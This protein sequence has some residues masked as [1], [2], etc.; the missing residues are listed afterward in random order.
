MQHSLFAWVG[1]VLFVLF[2]LFLDLGVFHKK[3]HRVSFREALGWTGV[4]IA[5]ALLFNLGV[6]FALG[7]ELALQFL[8]GYLIE[9]SLSVDNIF[10]ILLIF[11]YFRVPD[12]YQHKVLF[13]GI[14]GALTMRAVFIFGGLALIQKYR[15]VIYLFGGLL[16]F[17]GIRMSLPAK[18]EIALEKNFVL[19]MMR[20]FLPMVCSHDNGTFFQKQGGKTCATPLF[21]ALIIVETTD[22][23]F[24]VD[25][26]PA[27]LAISS[28]PFIVFTSNVFAILGLRSLYFA[29]AGLL[30]V[31]HHLKYGLSAI[32]VFVGTKMLLS[33]YYQLPTA[34]ALGIVIGI[35]GVSIVTS[36]IWP[37]NLPKNALPLNRQDS[38][39]I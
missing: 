25:S 31:F 23:I 9:K 37:K 33:G 34:F 13:W 21:A 36:L 35:L 15:W 19:R 17:S 32:L 39:T 30:D 29:V 6:Y 38:F 14:L 5:L 24:A 2:M 28:D 26:I 16:I 20:K 4:W 3:A 7:K 10:V 18:E 1:F 22:F 27:I 12:Q 11:T 8:T